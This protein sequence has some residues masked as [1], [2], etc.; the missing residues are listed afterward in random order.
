M[1]VAKGGEGRNNAGKWNNNNMQGDGT[2]TMMHENGIITIMQE[3]G[4]TP[5]TLGDGTI[6]KEVTMMLGDGS[7][8]ILIAIVRNPAT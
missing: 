2:I 1:L 7:T 5:I 6:T 8:R 4:T 3:G